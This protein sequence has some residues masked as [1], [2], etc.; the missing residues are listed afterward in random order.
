VGEDLIDE[1][2]HTQTHH[3]R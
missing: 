2:P 1:V 3:T